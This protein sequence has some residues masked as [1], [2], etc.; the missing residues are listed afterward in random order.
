MVRTEPNQAFGRG[1]RCVGMGSGSA[2]KILTGMAPHQASE[3]KSLATSMAFPAALNLA[4]NAWISI[5]WMNG[6]LNNFTK[7]TELGFYSRNEGY[8]CALSPQS[9]ACS[10]RR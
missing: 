2:K 6:C 10:Q 7:D 5:E 8:A 4:F 9:D 1:S 3:L